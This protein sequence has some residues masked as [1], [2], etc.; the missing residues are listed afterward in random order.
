MLKYG[1]GPEATKE[2][3]WDA[4]HDRSLFGTD[5]LA[6]TN[7]YGV[8]ANAG[9]GAGAGV[10]AV[11]AG[12]GGAGMGD[13]AGGDDGRGGGDDCS[14]S[15]GVNGFSPA[16]SPIL[17]KGSVVQV[18]EGSVVQGSEHGSEQTTHQPIASTTANTSQHHRHRPQLQSSTVSL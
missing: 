13:G 12:V 10:G 6:Q 16:R 15:G 1:A 3:S 8:G 4:I 14:E 2:F 11:A 5:A 17:R 18:S 7:T 9:T